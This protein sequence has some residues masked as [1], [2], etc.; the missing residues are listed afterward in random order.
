MA[1]GDGGSRDMIN[2][3][4]R[5]SCDGDAV[6]IVP[7]CCFLTSFIVCFLFYFMS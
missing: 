7:Y 2:D 3:D 6:F 1:A 4:K 5:K